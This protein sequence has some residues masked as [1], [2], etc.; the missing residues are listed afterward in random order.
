M[1]SI[2][3]YE[4]K[5]GRR[6]RVRYR[7]PDHSSTDKRGFRRKRDAEDWAA[8]TLASINDGMYVDPQ[9][10][11]RTVDQVAQ[12]WLTARKVSLKESSYHTLLVSYGAHVKPKWGDRSVRSLD[13]GEIQE[14]VTGLSARR[15]RSVVSR[16]MGILKR[17][18]DDAVKDNLIPRNPC[19]GISLPKARPP[20]KRRYLTM[21]QLVTVAAK[22]GYYEPLILTLGLCGLR[23]G[24]AIAITCGDIDYERR[25]ITISKSVTLVGGKHVRS[26]PKNGHSR[27]VA[28]PKALE[29]YLRR[30]TDGRGPGDLAFPGK[31]GGYIKLRS[32]PMEP[33]S[34]WYKA[35][36]ESGLEPMR[37][38]DLRHTAASLMVSAGAN[39]KAVQRQLGH[40]SASMTLDVYADL[41]DDDLDD[42]EE[43]MDTMIA[44]RGQKMGTAESGGHKES[45]E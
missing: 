19:E 42:V 36:A 15:S 33:T 29:P 40:S 14:W 21:S 17:V 27:Q 38:H 28:Y 5:S 23:W 6:W 1:A 20:Q 22:C 24:E 3:A 18:C 7:K 25:R 43:V 41:F 8:R 11:L 4:T 16:S 13:R 30:L 12:S 44:S 31:H 39:V 37:F 10:G 35:L 9:A 32:S 2:E 34:W 26:S 45:H